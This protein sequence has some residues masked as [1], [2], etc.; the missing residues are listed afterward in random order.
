MEVEVGI[1]KTNRAPTKQPKAKQNEQKT[2]KLEFQETHLES[3]N[4]GGWI[5]RLIELDGRPMKTVQMRDEE[6]NTAI[7]LETDG[8]EAEMMSRMIPWFL[9]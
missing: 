8:C 4:Y 1:P 5:G 3:H 6:S 7:N 2:R 9:S